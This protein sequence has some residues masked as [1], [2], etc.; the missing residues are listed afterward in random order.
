V[1]SHKRNEESQMGRRIRILTEILG[2][3]GWKVQEG[4]FED[5]QGRRFVPV[6]GYGV[7][8]DARLV[9]RTKRQWL[10]HGS[11]CGARCR[12]AA[13][14]RLRTR[15]WEDLP[16]AG[17]PVTIEAELIRVKCNKCKRCQASPVELRIS[18]PS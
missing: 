6:E 16:W 18:R 5:A 14:E 2:F 4:Y 13:H 12:A 7:M 10:P 3:G 8:P 15:R 1:F 11:R 17:R 9:L